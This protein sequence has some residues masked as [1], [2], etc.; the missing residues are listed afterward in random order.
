MNSQFSPA[1]G[2]EHIKTRH[3]TEV[4]SLSL[5]EGGDFIRRGKILLVYAHRREQARVRA[6]W[7]KK[8]EERAY[9]RQRPHNC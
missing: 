9:L 1:E 6:S 5:G 3:R 2:G 4:V 7:R 8:E